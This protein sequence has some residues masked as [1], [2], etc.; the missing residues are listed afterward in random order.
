MDPFRSHLM[1]ASRTEDYLRE[2]AADRRA[3][4]L[5]RRTRAETAA[6]RQG[7]RPREVARPVTA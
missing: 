7:S 2:A 5:R 6:P 4:P 1:A 3:G